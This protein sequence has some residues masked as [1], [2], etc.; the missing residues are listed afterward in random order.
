MN[1]WMDKLFFF[2]LF[3]LAVSCKKETPTYSP[4]TNEL[5]Y[6]PMNGATWEN[7]TLADINW[8]APDTADLYSFLSSNGTRAF[9]ILKDGK[10]VIEK[11]WGQNILNTAPFNQAT[12]WYWASAGKTLTAFLVGIAQ[13]K[14]LLSINDKSSKYLGP[15]W[16][17]LSP[18]KEDLIL[19]KHQLTMTTGL[20][21][22]T[23]DL[24]CTDPACLQYKAD[25]GSQWFYHNAAYKLLESVVSNAAGM[26][27]NNFT[28]EEVKSK[29]G[30]NGSWLPLGSNNVFW[31]D[32]RS[33]ARFGLLL[34]GKGKWANNQIMTD[35][36]YFN[37]MV[38]SSQTLNPAYG[39]LTWLNGKSSIILPSLPNSFPLLLSVNAPSDLFAAMGKN[40]QYIDVVPS[41]NL[42]V[43]RMG[44]A[45]DNN[46]VPTVFHD[47]MWKKIN[48]VIK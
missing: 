8:S 31:S 5:Y 30:M 14:A 15:G 40:G 23:G 35:Q 17:S 1:A 26:S 48:A 21:Y 36:N 25:A 9:I 45:P 3:L 2:L 38:N 39:Y 43:I 16:T 7:S 47:D 12:N 41:Q 37:A 19:I 11:Y 4:S 24:D 10:I 22:T 44:E 28:D 27:Y 29:T 18:Q 42:V 20:D 33:A 32:A 34:L 6:P 13:Q 46:L